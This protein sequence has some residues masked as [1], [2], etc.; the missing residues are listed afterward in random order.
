MFFQ[1]LPSASSLLGAAAN[2]CCAAGARTDCGWQHSFIV[3]YVQA[4]PGCAELWAAQRRRSDPG[5][6]RVRLASRIALQEEM[7]A[8]VQADLDPDECFV[9]N[10]ATTRR[11]QPAAISFRPSTGQAF[12]LAKSQ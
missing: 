4:L 5:L 7:A 9:L 2:G 1:L 10:R 6:K 3:Q 12:C 8:D 11:L